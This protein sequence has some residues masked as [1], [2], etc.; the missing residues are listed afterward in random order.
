VPSAGIA[1]LSGGAKP[2]G[3]QAVVANSTATAVVR[4]RKI[5]LSCGIACLCRG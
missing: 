2:L 1:L 4:E 3:G 5:R